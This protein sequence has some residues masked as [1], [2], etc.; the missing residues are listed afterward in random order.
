M[1]F[2]NH[3]DWVDFC[4]ASVDLFSNP[5]F[6]EILFHKLGNRVI[7]QSQI[8]SQPENIDQKVG[9][10]CINSVDAFSKIENTTIEKAKEAIIT[11]GHFLLFSSKLPARIIGKSGNTHGA[12]IVSIHAKNDII[13]SII[14]CF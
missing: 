6:I 4:R 5:S 14:D 12:R 7:I 3:V 9:G 1:F 10:T 2:F 8:I 13:S 11:N